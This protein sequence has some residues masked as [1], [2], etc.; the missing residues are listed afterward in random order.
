MDIASGSVDE[1]AEHLVASFQNLRTK[2]LA[3]DEA[4][5]IASRRLGDADSLQTEFA[6]VEHGS[7]AL[8]FGIATLLGWLVLNAIAFLARM[9][10]L[11]G[12]IA[13]DGRV[14]D[15]A[16]G[17]SGVAAAAHA[18]AALALIR[19][20]VGAGGTRWGRMVRAFRQAS[21]STQVTVVLVG[22]AAPFLNC[23]ANVLASHTAHVEQFATAAL[24]NAAGNFAVQ[25]AVIPALA[26]WML[27]RLRRPIPEI[28]GSPPDGCEGRR[29]VAAG[30]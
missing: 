19:I 15:H 17:Y 25:V 16:L 20:I 28:P 7:R 13:T 22:A 3:E 5:L 14:G 9:V 1:L 26:I 24:L 10:V 23:W 2:G 21:L 29:E 8:E 18:V 4:F 30:D 6:K 12:T 27:T 11:W